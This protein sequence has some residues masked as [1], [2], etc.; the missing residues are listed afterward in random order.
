MPDVTENILRHIP[1][2][3]RYARVLTGSQ[4]DGDEY[5]RLC[6]ERL[7]ENP[8]R[9]GSDNTRFQLFSMFHKVCGDVASPGGA[10]GRKPSSDLKERNDH[11]PI[12]RASCRERVWQYV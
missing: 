9:I 3:R 12:R 8:D 5:V 7:V 4:K 1:S 6:L 2:L 10:R 11:Q